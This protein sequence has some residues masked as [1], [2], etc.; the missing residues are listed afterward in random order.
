MPINMF[1]EPV[2]FYGG[3]YTFFPG[4]STHATEIFRSMTEAI[5]NK[6]NIFTE[7]FRNEIYDGVLFM[8]ELSK[9]LSTQAGISGLVRGNETLA[10]RLTNQK[11]ANL[12]LLICRQ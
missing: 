7:A 11:L 10:R 3:N 5:F 6:R 8:L 9:L 12:L 2:V 1:A 4:I